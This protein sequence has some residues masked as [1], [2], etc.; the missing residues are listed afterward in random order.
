MS[1]Q[2]S[3]QGSSEHETPRLQAEVLSQQ[4]SR[5]ARLL[6]TVKQSKIHSV[7]SMV[8]MAS[9]VVGCFWAYVGVE[10]GGHESSVLSFVLMVL[11]ILVSENVGIH[12]RID[13]LIELL[14]EK[15]LLR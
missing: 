9:V 15:R 13:A 5:Q 7:V 11:I 8:F 10:R 6:K 12:T 14:N 3:G 1:E 2:Q 4:L